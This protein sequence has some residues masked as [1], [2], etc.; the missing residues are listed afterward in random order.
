MTSVRRSSEGTRSLHFPAKVGDGLTVAVAVLV[1]GG[2]SVEVGTGDG[3]AGGQLDLKVGV[4]LALE[5]VV[6]MTEVDS[7]EG[8]TAELIVAVVIINGPLASVVSLPLDS[9]PLESLPLE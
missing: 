5:G 6:A 2:V 9:L 8:V 7:C 3:D 4:L 1:G